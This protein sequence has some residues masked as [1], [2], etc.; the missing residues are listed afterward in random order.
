M[1]MGL[2]VSMVRLNRVI[3]IVTSRAQE[4][5]PVD[6]ESCNGLIKDLENGII[7][8]GREGTWGIEVARELGPMGTADRAGDT[9][10]ADVR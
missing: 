5:A 6:S 7:L 4:R 8:V 1:E 2:I 3:I 10:M 9:S